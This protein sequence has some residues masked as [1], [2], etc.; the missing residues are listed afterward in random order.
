MSPRVCYALLLVASQGCFSEPQPEIL[1]TGGPGPSDTSATTSTSD[2]TG[3]AQTS[4]SGGLESSSGPDA[5]DVLDTGTSDSTGAAERCGNGRLDGDE[6]C[7]DGNDVDGDGCDACTLGGQVNWIALAGSELSNIESGLG[8][9]FTPDGGVVATGAIA[10]GTG[11]S[12]WIERY[13]AVGRVQWLRTVVD[14]GG[15]LSAGNS[16]AV[17]AQG[18]IYVAGTLGGPTGGLDQFLRKYTADGEALWTYVQDHSGWGDGL[19]AVAVASDD[20]VVVGGLVS[21]AALDTD[22]QV[23]AVDGELGT[24]L[25]APFSFTGALVDNVYG[26]DLDAEGHPRVSARTAGGRVVAGWE[27]PLPGDPAWQSG[28]AGVDGSVG[29]A[30]DGAGFTAACA[31]AT[32]GFDADAWVGWF[33]PSGKLVWSITHDELGTDD[34]CAAVAI[35]PTGRIVVVGDVAQGGGASKMLAM[36]LSDE[37]EVLWAHQ[38]DVGDLGPA[39]ALGVAVD[40]DGSIALTGFAFTERFGGQIATVMLRP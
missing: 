24:P 6:A 3:P 8:V 21:V 37:G 7:D 19:S 39:G 35:D 25:G 17:D 14:D 12:I 30:T 18:S 34:N 32:V 5:G 1:S 10:N 20:T 23:F 33:D 13:A 38:L 4:S 36:K 28:L 15:S 26:L 22:G 40:V 27:E 11:T 9:A 29:I 16:V 31:R 2:D